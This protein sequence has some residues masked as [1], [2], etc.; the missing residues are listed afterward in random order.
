MKRVVRVLLV[1]VGVF[2]LAPGTVSAQVIAIDVNATVTYISHPE[3]L[4]GLVNVGDTMTG[5]Y[6]YDSESTDANPLPTVGDYWQY[7]APYGVRLSVGGFTFA[8]DPDD[9]RFLL[10]VGN[11]HGSPGSYDFYLFRSYE[12]LGLPNGVEVDHISWQL[13][14]YSGTALSSDDWPDGSTLRINYGAWGAGVLRANVTSVVPEP[15]T[16]FL[17]ALGAIVLLRVKRQP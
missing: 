8:S 10:E 11:D 2:G 13:D 14:D 4:D 15:A 12:N 3:L 9:T 17:L 5:W 1:V 16:I 6:A 7:T